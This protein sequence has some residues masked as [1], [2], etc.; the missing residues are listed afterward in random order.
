MAE[1][2]NSRPISTGLSTVK[3]PPE[4]YPRDGMDR[5]EQQLLRPVKR[6]KARNHGI[7]LVLSLSSYL[8]C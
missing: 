5:E 2:A 3:K 7:A 8:F 1:I 4:S 6:I